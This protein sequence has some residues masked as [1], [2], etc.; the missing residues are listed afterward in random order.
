MGIVKIRPRGPGNDDSAGK[1]SRTFPLN[2]L[3]QEE[4]LFLEKST[5]DVFDDGELA[6][7][8]CEFVMV[9]DQVCNVPYDLY[10][11]QNLKEILSL[12]IWNSG[13]TEEERFSLAA[14]LLDMDQQTFWITIK[15]LLNGDN[16]FFGSPLE[17]FFFRLKGGFYSPQVSHLRE[18]LQ[19]LQRRG[20]YHSLRSYHENMCQKCV[21][22]KRA[23]SNCHPSM[24]E[25]RKP[26]FLVDLNAFPAEE[27]MLNKGEK[28]AA[29][30]PLLKKTKYMNERVTAHDPMV[31]FKGIALNRKT[32]AKGVLKIKP[33]EM[34]AMQN[35]PLLPLPNEPW[36]PCRR[37]P[38]GV[39]KI[40]PKCDLLGHQ[41]E[42]SR[43]I[44][45]P[46]EQTT[47]DL[48]GVHNSRFSPSQFAFTW[49]KQTF[50]EK[51]QF[52][53]RTGRDGNTYR[54]PELIENQQREEFLNMGAGQ[55]SQRKRK[56]VKDVRSD[57][58]IE[59]N[60]ETFPL[61]NN[62]KLRIYSHETGGMGKHHD[63]ENLWQNSGQR[64]KEFH[65]GSA[66]SYPISPGNHRGR[67][68]MTAV[69][70]TL[71]EAVS[72]APIVLTDEHQPFTKSS[73]HSKHKL[74][75]NNDGV[76][77]M[78]NAQM[79]TSGVEREGLMFP[80]TYKR[81]KAY[82]KLNSVTSLKQLPVVADVE[83]VLPSGKVDMKA[84]AIKIKFKGWNDKNAEYKQ[85][86]L[87][88]MQHGSMSS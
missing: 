15:E 5:G 66:D 69:H 6:E 43:M 14:Y 79:A 27:E 19:F 86:M 41:R 11:L 9:E 67:M 25:D 60:E 54:S 26:V 48:S 81:K 84:K 29:T 34:N 13:L 74:R 7:V 35:Q 32:N 47:A 46:P 71:S 24:R 50:D 77:K 61:K 59:I 20:Y 36:E 1:R 57:N 58:A 82:T 45:V 21:D 37:P 85:G 87:N 40:K 83:S 23:W 49:D 39:L 88:G 73:D 28:N 44:Q 55:R 33:I 53:H 56:M 16:M 63:G 80:I 70:S 4:G 42:R 18:S 78:P 52:V 75:D 38:K 8:G 72:G 12:E 22:I 76:L 65:A 30:I 3:T 51:L 2:E 68:Q 62:L 64:S 10:D 17:N 31:V